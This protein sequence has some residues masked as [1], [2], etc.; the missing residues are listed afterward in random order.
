ME[1]LDNIAGPQY[2]SAIMWTVGALVLLVIVL[3]L[4]RIVRGVSS[5]TFVAG[6]R[7]RRARLAIMD[8]AAIDN[9]RRLVLVRRDDVEH[10]ILIGGPT[11]VVVEQNIVPATARPSLPTE[12]GS[13]LPNGRAAHPAP[14][15]PEGP[16]AARQE[17]QEPVVT[18]EAPIDRVAESVAVR[19][20]RSEP[21]LSI[22]RETPLPVAPVPLAREAEAASVSSPAASTNSVHFLDKARI[23]AAPPMA[24]VAPLGAAV[25]ETRSREYRAPEITVPERETAT[26]EAVR[27]D[28]DQSRE[29]FRR[30]AGAADLDTALQEELKAPLADAPEARQA[31]EPSLEEEMK[32]LLGELSA[33][34]RG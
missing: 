12:S 21:V 13:D 24:G 11:D 33:P 29:A 4:V 7:N 25:G 9:Q 22:E 23:S 15:A 17:R 10:L 2:A 20:P 14:S 28:V 5:G 34:A 16:S 31:A 1:W 18:A 3:F 27:D 19:A 30:E 26:P 32:R 8:A 6:G